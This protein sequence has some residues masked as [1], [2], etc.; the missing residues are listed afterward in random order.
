MNLQVC[1]D[2]TIKLIN[3]YSNSGNLTPSTDPNRLDYSLRFRSLQDTA[4]KEIAIFKKIQKYFTVLE[5]DIVKTDASFIEI[6]MPQDYYQ[7]DKVEY[8]GGPI[9]WK[10]RGRRK[11]IVSKNTVFPIDVFYYAYP[12]EITDKTPNTYEFE[13]DIEAQEAI[14]YYVAAHVLMDEQGKANV[15]SKLLAIYQG[16]LANLDTNASTG[17]AGIKN[18]LFSG[19]G[20]N[21]LF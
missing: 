8:D 9:K 15:S 7:M 14:P 19:S 4:Q 12:Q 1:D 3:D 20:T 5:A 6:N 11:I 17:S 13:I 16:K 10:T 18:S 2:K 21:K